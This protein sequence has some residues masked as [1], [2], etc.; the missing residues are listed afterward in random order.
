MRARGTVQYASVSCS[1]SRSAKSL[2]QSCG[3]KKSGA[4]VRGVLSPALVRRG[5]EGCL[6]KKRHASD[7]PSTRLPSMMASA[8]VFRKEPHA[9]CGD[10]RRAATLDRRRPIRPTCSGTSWPAVPGLPLARTK[11]K[12]NGACKEAR[13]IGLRARTR[14][15]TQREGLPTRYEEASATPQ[16]RRSAGATGLGATRNLPPVARAAEVTFPSCLRARRPI[17]RRLP[18]GQR[19]SDPPAGSTVPSAGPPDAG[20]PGPRDAPTRTPGAYAFEPRCSMIDTD[21][22]SPSASKEASPSSALAAVGSPK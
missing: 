7:T 9:T 16:P 4:P 12:P 19:V 6:A 1:F 2:R 10:R 5:Q 18:S 17:G 21:R 13:P 11:L 22:I 20:T 3:A 14:S 8:V 15:R